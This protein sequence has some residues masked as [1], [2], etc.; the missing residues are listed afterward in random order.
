MDETTATPEP[1]LPTAAPR[2]LARRLAAPLALA[3]AA[4]AV[5]AVSA[6]AITDG[7]TT[8]AVGPMPAAQYGAMG[9]QMARP[10]RSPDQMRGARS[11]ARAARAG[12]PEHLEALAETLGVSV[13]ELTAAR[14]V[15]RAAR[16]DQVD[17]EAD[18]MAQR[19]VHRAAAMELMASEL[20]ID[21]DTLVAAVEEHRAEHGAASRMR[22]RMGAHRGAGA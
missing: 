15:A 1:T 11:A 6:V 22:E 3:V 21:V 9:E 14:D 5:G 10:V 16:P 18:R 20:G 13:E 4:A 2:S 17:R 12:Q 19:E 7:R 8:D